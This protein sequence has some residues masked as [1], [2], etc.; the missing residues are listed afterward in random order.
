MAGA[1]F[2]MPTIGAP[3]AAANPRDEPS[4]CTTCTFPACRNALVALG[5]LRHPAAAENNLGG[6]RSAVLRGI[7]VVASNV[8]PNTKTSLG[9]CTVLSRC[10]GRIEIASAYPGVR[11][12]VR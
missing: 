11:A 2:V 10:H 4:P 9:R 5:L 3:S 8:S 6:S 12:G 1:P 7:A